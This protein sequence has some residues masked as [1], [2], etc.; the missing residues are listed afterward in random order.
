MD[1]HVR[2]HVTTAAIVVALGV[3]VSAITS[4]VVVARAYTQRGREAN[5]RGQTITVKG[6]TRERIQSDRAVWVIRVRG[7]GRALPDAFAV[8]ERG[9][10]RVQQFLKGSGFEAPEI[11]LGSI[12]TETQ[13][14]RDAKGEPTHEVV[15]YALQRSF[16]VST[17]QVQ[18]V[19][20]CAGRVTELLQEGVL[21]ASKA[22]AYYFT[23]LPQLKIDLMASA[24]GDA[25]ARA[26]KIAASTGC[27]LGELRDAQMGVLQITRPD[28]T[29][30]ADY[31][32]YD[33]STIDKD[34][35]A[36]VT[37]T[38]GIDAG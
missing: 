23:K 14:A 25:R 16:V 21:V 36:V 13:Y 30:V 32:L 26:D 7:E 2:L 6:S 35:N 17:G 18:R 19:E 33:T 37:A 38:F 29:E 3:V 28:S 5:H 12:D 4:T 11:G 9:V 31:G 24:S 27:K 34:V 10:T 8:L 20:Q 15:A 1:Y 22:P